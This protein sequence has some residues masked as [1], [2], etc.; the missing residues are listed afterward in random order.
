MA[1][2]L[3]KATIRVKR[4][5]EISADEEKTL[6]SLTLDESSMMQA[7]MD[8]EN[9]RNGNIIIAYRGKYIAGWAMLLES[10]LRYIFYVFVKKSRRRQGIGTQILEK[11]VELSKRDNRRLVVC[12]WDTASRAFYQATDMHD[13]APGYH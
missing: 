7:Y 13:Y 12:P 2:L 5:K 3:T 4:L 6:R 11:A 8:T 1:Q 9:A 10:G